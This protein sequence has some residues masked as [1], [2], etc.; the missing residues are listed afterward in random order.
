MTGPCK[1]HTCNAPDDLPGCFDCNHIFTEYEEQ[2]EDTMGN[3][4]C[5]NCRSKLME[6]AEALYKGMKKEAALKREMDGM[7]HDRRESDRING[8]W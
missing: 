7:K 6:Q 4:Q 3:P 5:W 1:C 8:R 2:F